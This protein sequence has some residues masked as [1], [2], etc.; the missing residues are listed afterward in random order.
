MDLARCPPTRGHHR[1]RG[2]DPG[3]G[4]QYSHLDAGQRKVGVAPSSR[5]ALRN[6]FAVELRCGVLNFVEIAHQ[7]FGLDLRRQGEAAGKHEQ[8]RGGERPGGADKAAPRQTQARR[9]RLLGGGYVICTR[10][11]AAA[12]AGRPA[13]RRRWRVGLLPRPRR[14]HALGARRS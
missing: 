1:R 14:S 12:P 6:L 8:R 3:G 9:A 10:R 5:E 2:G 13:V 7:H 4:T 11:G